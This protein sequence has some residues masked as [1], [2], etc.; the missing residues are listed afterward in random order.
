MRYSDLTANE[1]FQ[2]IAAC[3][4]SVYYSD[5]RSHSVFP[6]A[7]N[8]LVEVT[9]PYHPDEWFD[10]FVDLQLV[11]AEKHQVTLSTA[12]L[13]W[14]IEQLG[15]ERP[16]AIVSLLLAYATAP[17]ETLT[18]VEMAERTGAAESGWRNKAA[19]GLLPGA[20]KKGKQW[21]IPARYAK[22]E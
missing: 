21:L 5:E 19:A 3:I 9:W 11:M 8:Q 16:D 4:R 14:L 18:P 1:N 15:T 7:Y 6:T 13:D 10:R 2:D 17:E 20:R 12:N 22:A